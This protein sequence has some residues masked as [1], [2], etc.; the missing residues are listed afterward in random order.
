MSFP[1]KSDWW[2][3][4]LTYPTESLEGMAAIAQNSGWVVQEVRNYLRKFEDGESTFFYCWERQRRGTLHLHYA[5]HLPLARSAGFSNEQFHGWAVR[6]VHNLS[7][8]SGCNLW[9]NKWGRDWSTSPKNLQSYAQKIE[10]S[11][12]RYLAKYVSKEATKNSVSHA[13]SPSPRRW[14][15]RSRNLKRL[16]DELTNRCEKEFSSYTESVQA[17]SR[18]RAGLRLRFIHADVYE[19][20]SAL[21]DC[22]CLSIFKVSPCRVLRNFWNRLKNDFTRLLMVNK[23]TSLSEFVLSIQDLQLLKDFALSVT[24]LD[25]KESHFA[26]FYSTLEETASWSNYAVWNYRHAASR[27]TLAL[28]EALVDW[29]LLR[30]RSMSAQAQAEAKSLAS[31]SAYLRSCNLSRKVALFATLH[32]TVLALQTSTSPDTWIQGHLE[33]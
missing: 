20:K 5:V 6:H 16:T 32:S 2:F 3:L 13:K 9:I 8:R 22:D 28:T 21:A 7:A 1:E 23:G 19:S 25:P 4:T 29:Q 18:L 10:K 24:G 30:L 11:V 31:F 26:S 33:V 14:W 12:S 27:M 17:Y 15:G